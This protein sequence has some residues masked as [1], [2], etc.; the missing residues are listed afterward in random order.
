MVS[1]KCISFYGELE[2]KELTKHF[3]THLID[4]LFLVS[5]ED[6]SAV[7]ARVRRTMEQIPINT[8]N[9]GK[10]QQIQSG[11]RG[12]MPHQQL[13]NLQEEKTPNK[14]LDIPLAREV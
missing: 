4:R 10:Q 5:N 11:A 6:K 8:W 9:V 14:N 13:I 2:H 3:E 7:F 12:M 1:Q